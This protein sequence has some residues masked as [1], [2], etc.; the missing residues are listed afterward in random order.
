MDG[1]LA[2]ALVLSYTLE[3][4]VTYLEI[5]ATSRDS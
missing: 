5:K 1:D 3:I 2:I 4:K